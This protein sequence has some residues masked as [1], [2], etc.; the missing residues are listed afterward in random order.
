MLYDPNWDSKKNAKKDSS[1][2]WRG[3][4]LLAADEVR[5]RG[6]AKYTQMDRDGRVCLHGAVELARYGQ[7]G[8]GNNDRI[9]CDA[10]EAL[11][12]HLKEAHGFEYSAPVITE[13]GAADWNNRP[14]RTASEVI[15]ALEG[16]A[17]ISDDA[18]SRARKIAESA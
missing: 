5:N 8:R 16:A 11:K 4:L 9:I 17:K 1:G 10:F 13:W 3:I 14:E 2:D 7:V 6:L 18:V 15:D 12:I